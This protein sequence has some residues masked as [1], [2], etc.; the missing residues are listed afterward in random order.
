MSTLSPNCHPLL[1]RLIV[2]PSLLLKC[3]LFSVA[4]LSPLLCRLI[5]TPSLLLTCH[6]FSVTQ[7]SPL[8][9][10]P[11]VVKVEWEKEDVSLLTETERQVLD[12][13]HNGFL[14]LLLSFVIQ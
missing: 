10:S 14:L 12:Y 5:I 8:L 7:L 1:C 4:Q 13:C 3:H 11:D 9:C 6:P 2:T